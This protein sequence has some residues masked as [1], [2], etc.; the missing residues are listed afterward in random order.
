MTEEWDIDPEAL[1]EAVRQGLRWT[2]MELSDP[3]WKTSILLSRFLDDGSLAVGVKLRGS[4]KS[5]FGG[6]SSS[7]IT[8][9][10][11]LVEMAVTDAEADTAAWYDMDPATELQW[12][13]PEWV[14]SDDLKRAVTERTIAFLLQAV[15]SAVEKAV[16]MTIDLQATEQDGD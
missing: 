10:E 1:L 8:A 9:W 2:E 5:P 12:Q 16:A 6:S 13:R 3:H 4:K 7:H 11:K 15:T 14:N